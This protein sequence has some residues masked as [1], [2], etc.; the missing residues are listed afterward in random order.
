MSS[1]EEGGGGVGDHCPMSGGG[2]MYP[3]PLSWGEGGSHAKYTIG[4]GHVG[5]SLPLNRMKE[6]YI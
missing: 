3:D 4:N 1:R 5:T 2:G 6:R